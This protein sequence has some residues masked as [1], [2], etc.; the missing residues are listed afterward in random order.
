MSFV[1]LIN[2]GA[3]VVGALGVKEA[4]LKM[5]V[6]FYSTAPNFLFSKIFWVGLL[7]G[8][9][10][11]LFW[12]NDPLKFKFKPPPFVWLSALLLKPDEE[13][14]NILG[15]DVGGWENIDFYYWILY[16]GGFGLVYS[17]FLNMFTLLVLFVNMLVETLLLSISDKGLLLLNKPPFPTYKGLAG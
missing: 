11:T 5:F 7:I 14:V 12:N 4:F 13:L 16:F 3:L 1:G 8:L 9:P 15:V 17:L 10:P 6:F 2:N